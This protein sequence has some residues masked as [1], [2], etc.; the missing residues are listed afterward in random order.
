MATAMSMGH[1]I[2][3]SDDES[4]CDGRE[5]PSLLRKVTPRKVTPKMK[6]STASTSP[7]KV[8]PKRT[9]PAASAASTSHRVMPSL[10][11]HS[12]KSRQHDVSDSDDTDDSEDDNKTIL[13]LA[14]GR[15]NVNNNANRS[16][17]SVKNNKDK[18]S[19]T[20]K[21]DPAA[22]PGSSKQPSSEVGKRKADSPA[23]DTRPV[24][25]YGSECFRKNKWHMEEFRHPGRVLRN[26]IFVSAVENKQNN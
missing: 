15:R 26:Y 22:T 18:S 2:S 23:K 17:P 12:S 7:R 1:A 5:S 14:G 20:T 19:S 10:S 25:K 9:A 21:R 16:S 24:C 11:R 13:G 8:T 4:S 3:D 6:P